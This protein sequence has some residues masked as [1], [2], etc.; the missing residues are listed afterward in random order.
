M[1]LL[2]NPLSPFVRI[3]QVALI[4][5]GFDVQVTEV[6]PWADDPHLRSAN[7]AARIPT[8]ILDDGQ[9][10]TE[11]LLIVS[12]LE[13]TRQAPQWPSLYGRSEAES[14]GVLSRSGVAFGAIEAS[15]QTI[16]TRRVTAPL[17]F[18]ETLVGMRRCRTMREAL[19]RLEAMADDLADRGEPLRLDQLC[20]VTLFDYQALRYGNEPWHP[21]TPRLAALST[22][23]REKYRSIAETAPRLLT[24]G[25]IHATSMSTVVAADAVTK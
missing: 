4:E 21:K 10:L 2:S 13:R 1:E 8:L 3:A 18:D 24:T 15:V 16:I 6:D 7:V 20:A 12:W 17:S 14:V 11:A 9:A 25:G 5:K 23:L 22:A 19:Q